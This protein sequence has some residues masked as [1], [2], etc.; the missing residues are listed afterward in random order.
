[1]TKSSSRMSLIAPAIFLPS[2][3]HVVFGVECAIR[4]LRK[5][6][7]KPRGKYDVTICVTVIILL[8]I[9]SWVPTQIHKQP[10]H[11]FASL[12]WFVT[13]F[14]VIGLSI[15]SSIAFFAISSSV[16]IFYRLSTHKMI[17]QHER[18]AASRVVY[19]LILKL[20]GLV[21]IYSS[22]M[23][24][25]LITLGVCNTLVCRNDHQRTN[26]SYCNDGNSG[27]KSCRPH[28]WS[29]TAFFKSKHRYHFIST[30]RDTW[31]E[32]KKA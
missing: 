2:Y 4:S 9:G 16:T 23:Y 14:G 31:L 5:E 25:N 22:L 29:F 6:P 11:C 17:D 26:Y 10:N 24:C 32:W 28:D 19:Y 7:F 27:V 8:V 18:I 20:I 12:M 1:M 30:E 3:I 21:R 15:L 13:N